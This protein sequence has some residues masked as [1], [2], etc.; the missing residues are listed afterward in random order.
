M[1]KSHVERKLNVASSG[2]GTPNHLGGEM[3]KYMAKLDIVHVAYK[4]GGPA[5]TDLINAAVVKARSDTESMVT[6]T[7]YSAY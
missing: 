2:I 3:L 7:T 6:F 4:G 1:N 5:M